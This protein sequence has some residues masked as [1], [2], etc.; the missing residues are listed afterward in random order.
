M[1][2]HTSA[3]EP[4]RGRSWIQRAL[5]ALNGLLVVAA[6]ATAGW[7][8]YVYS[9]VRDLE[10]VNLDAVLR[11]GE[12]EP[13][14]EEE[15]KATPDA[16]E[17]ERP[18]S[19]P[20]NFL[21]V[22]SDSREFIDSGEDADSF[23][24]VASPP[25]A[26][27][28]LLARVDP[29]AK[30]A[31]L[32][33]F[34]RDLY[35]D[36]AG[37]EGR[38]RINTA[39][40]NGPGALIQTI[41]ENFDVSIDHYVQVDFEGFRELIDSIGGIELW[42]SYPVRDWG[43]P[44]PGEPLRNISGLDISAT[45]CVLLDGNQ[46]L[47]YV[48]SR[49]FEQLVEGRWRPDP[50]GDLGRIQRQQDLVV[51]A[52]AK[53]LREGLFNPVR[54]LRILDAVDGHLFTDDNLDPGEAIDLAS[55]L[56]GLDVQTIRR[57]TIPT[58]TFITPA[59]ANVQV[60]SDEAEVERI[61]QVFRGQAPAVPP[62]GSA[63]LVPAQ[64]TLTVV[65]GTGRGGEALGGRQG[66]EAAGFAVAATGDRPPFDTAATTVEH[67]PGQAAEAALV[68]RYLPPTVAVQEVPGEGVTVVTGTDFTGVAPTPRPEPAAPVP[69][70][71]PS[72]T[73]TTISEAETLVR[74]YAGVG[75]NECYA[76]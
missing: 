2:V 1:A 22:G 60:I 56:D 74:F 59:G 34:P 41:S 11:Q 37:E 36:I 9:R 54:L 40:G 51:R 35:L 31:A 32:V 45:G 50:T 7:G 8:G 19:E 49:H 23:G 71:V 28:I 30:T 65:N 68:A 15:R 70:P 16:V 46:A 66:F 12:D 64:V 10:S 38:N 13:T 62:A 52:V 57:D 72:T 21:L 5:I 29:V 63:E 73:T 55:Q 14:G 76:G 43:R 26:D 58:E 69:P 48:R 24:G 42:I 67:G 25:R 4:G 17:E 61:M 18:P 75:S 3:H 53:A 47:S 6:L 33:S 39:F 20:L 44:A 27:T